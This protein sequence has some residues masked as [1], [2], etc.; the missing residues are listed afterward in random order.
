MAEWY[1]NKI[2][3]DVWLMQIGHFSLIKC[4]LISSAHFKWLHNNC[5]SGH[6][7]HQ[8]SVVQI[9]SSGNFHLLSTDNRQKE[10]GNGLIV[11]KKYSKVS[12]INSSLARP[13]FPLDVDTELNSRKWISCPVWPDGKIISSILGQWKQWKFAQ[14]PKNGPDRFKILP[15]TK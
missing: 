14:Y 10:A 4:L 12:H 3:F 1:I 6:F 7:L 15:N 2:S 13:S 8:R 9:Q 5:W 11:W